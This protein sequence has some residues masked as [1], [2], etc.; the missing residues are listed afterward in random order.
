MYDGVKGERCDLDFEKQNITLI[1]KSLFGNH[2][3]HCLALTS[4]SK[5]N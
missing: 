5:P 4:F 3:A 2:D 1:E